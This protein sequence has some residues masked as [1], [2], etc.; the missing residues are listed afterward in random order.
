MICV[1]D[2]GEWKME[3]RVSSLG[4]AAAL[5]GVVCTFGLVDS[6]ITAPLISVDLIDDTELRQVYERLLYLDIDPT[7]KMLIGMHRT[8]ENLKEVLGRVLRFDTKHLIYKE[9]IEQAVTQRVCMQLVNKAV[10]FVPTDRL[11]ATVDQQKE[12][13]ARLTA[14]LQQA[15]EGHAQAEQAK[16]EEIA[17]LQTE[18]ERSREEFEQSQAVLSGAR[19][20]LATLG[21]QGREHRR[22][23]RFK[24]RL[25]F[26][27]LRALTGF[28]YRQQEV[29]KEAPKHTI[30]RIAKGKQFAKHLENKYSGGKPIWTGANTLVFECLGLLACVGVLDNEGLRG[31]MADLTS[32]LTE[33]CRKLP[34]RENTD[35]GY[36]LD[37]TTRIKIGRSLDKA[38]ETMKAYNEGAEEPP[39]DP[40]E[41]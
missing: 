6:R 34:T 24:D 22:T 29:T 1:I 2:N 30:H 33:L 35:V 32:K 27:L 19:E 4:C 40:F 10:A 15:Q 16:T 31:Q 18:L 41:I 28:D 36:H 25:T 21:K 5:V 23:L 7:A 9:D 3:K 17:E 26:L 37:A 13:I 39:A 14:A 11:Q 8:P 20:N 38:L 12:D